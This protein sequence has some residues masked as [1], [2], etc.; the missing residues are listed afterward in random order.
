MDILITVDDKSLDLLMPLG[1]F[2]NANGI[3]NAKLNIKGSFSDPILSGELNIMN[4]KFTPFA[5][6][7]NVYLENAKVIIDKNKCMIKEFVGKIDKENIYLYGNI[8]LKML[9]P[10]SVE[11]FV[12]S[13]QKEINFYL[14]GILE[15]KNGKM[16]ISGKE[17]EWFTITGYIDKPKFSGKLLVSKLSFTY[18]PSEISGK[19]NYDF[20]LSFDWD[21]KI[22][23]KE[24]V[25][26]YNQICNALVKKDSYLTFSGIGEKI[27]ISGMIDVEKG[28]FKYFG[29]DFD[30]TYAS[31]KWIDGEG[32]LSAKA[33]RK[34]KNVIII[35]NVTGKQD[36]L[37]IQLSSVPHLTH[38]QIASYLTTDADYTSLTEKEINEKFQNEFTQLLIKQGINI[39]VKKTG[40]EKV[41]KNLVALDEFNVTFGKNFFDRYE[42]TILP[43][44]SLGKYVFERVY[45]G[46]SIT[47]DYSLDSINRWKQEF[48][49]EYNLPIGIFHYKFS[50]KDFY[51]GY[52][53]IIRF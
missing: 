23:A 12:S 42:P 14:P 25:L 32:F 20:L 27:K 5:L 2:R 40:I 18:P 26:F 36:E 9:S 7:Q 10:E 49:I 34:I 44:I 45:L 6:F 53:K 21:L 29:Q 1:W 41:I 3:M 17:N 31:M 43:E 50:E 37:V 24:N 13:K 4:A 33:E 35:A 39:G 22:I 47:Q 30:I 38:Q 15:G 11:I 51:I 28:K 19:N 16:I 52:K 48:Q 46:Y 8:Y